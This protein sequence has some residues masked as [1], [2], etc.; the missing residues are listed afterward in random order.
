MLS[1]EILRYMLY[2]KV[3]TPTIFNRV[4]I[5]R[6]ILNVFADLGVNLNNIESRPSKEKT[7]DYNFFIEIESSEKVDKFNQ[8]INLLKQYCPVIKVLGQF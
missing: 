4:G 7:W 1:K 8:A 3:K 5:L 2:N 6:D